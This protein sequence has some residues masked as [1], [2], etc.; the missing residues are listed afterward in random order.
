MEPYG[1]PT[2]GNPTINEASP[3]YA[4]VR[5]ADAVTVASS[6]SVE[7]LEVSAACASGIEVASQIATHFARNR[8]NH[9][10]GVRLFA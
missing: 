10:T 3:R 4:R 1:S 8:A 2:P 7:F 5:D 6:I 9:K